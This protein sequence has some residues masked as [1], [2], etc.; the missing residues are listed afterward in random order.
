MTQRDVDLMMAS[1]RYS[2]ELFEKENG[3]VV[4]L[5]MAS[6]ESK[7]R[8]EVHFGILSPFLIT[9]I[10]FPYLPYLSILL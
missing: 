4:S 10:I 7:T 5:A 8:L 6:I 3:T 2:S 9:I 1:I